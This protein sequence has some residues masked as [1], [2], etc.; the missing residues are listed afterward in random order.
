MCDLNA[1]ALQVLLYMYASVYGYT[2]AYLEDRLHRREAMNH[3][4]GHLLIL[5]YGYDV[6]MPEGL[7]DL[8]KSIRENL[9][10]TLG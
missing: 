8:E 6:G 3:T 7:K 2:V 1:D 9:K 5:S 4:L 10:I